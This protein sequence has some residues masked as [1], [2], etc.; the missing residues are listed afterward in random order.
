MAGPLDARSACAMRCTRSSPGILP[1]LVARLSL[2]RVR[3]AG[4]DH[5]G[6]DPAAGGR[7]RLVELEGGDDIDVGDDADPAAMRRRT[8][9]GLRPGRPARLPSGVDPHRPKPAPVGA[10]ESPHRARRLVDAHP[11]ARNLHQLFRAATACGRVVSDISYLA[12]R[13]RPGCRPHGLGRGV[14][15]LRHAR[16]ARAIGRTPGQQRRR[17]ASALPAEITRAVS[18]LARSCHTTVNIVLQG[19]WALLLLAGRR[20]RDVAFGTT[21]SGRPAELADAESMVGLLINT[22]PVR[23]AITSAT[24]KPARPALGQLVP[25]TTPWSISTWHSARFTASRV[26]RTSCSTPLFA[27]ENLPSASTLAWPWVTT[28]SRG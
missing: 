25:I 1:Q 2:R 26:G 28:G 5:P 8:R 14:R 27:F 17:V 13:A 20:Q 4:A 22:V 3:P 11:A 19:A 24:T 21:V 16:P 6:A 15:R 7:G 10:D 9:R 18:E 12:G 23:A